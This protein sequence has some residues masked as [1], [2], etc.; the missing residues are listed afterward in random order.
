MDNKALR[1]FEAR[2]WEA[3]DDLRANSKLTSQQYCMPVLGLIFLRYADSRFRLVTAELEKDRPTR[4][5]KVLPISK[6]EY[7]AKSALYL[8]EEARYPYLVNLP[9]NIAALQ[10]TDSTGKTM[11]S[12]GEVVNHAMELIEKESE[13]LSGVL[14]REYTEFPDTLLRELLRNFNNPLLDDVDGDVIGRIYEYFL[15]KFAKSVA[16]DDGVFFT[17]KSLVKMIVNVIEPER[18]VLLEQR[19]LGLIQY[20]ERCA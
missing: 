7:M 11:N 18:G 14:P 12:I 9:E 16:S 6:S 20:W 17:P 3:A 2:L 10:L 15:N 19:C 8:P 1:F 5:G 13:N 4:H